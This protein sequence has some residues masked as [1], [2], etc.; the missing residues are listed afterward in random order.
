MTTWRRPRNRNA[1]N[2]PYTAENPN[3]RMEPTTGFTD[4]M[5]HDPNIMTQQY[6]AQHNNND[7]E[8]NNNDN[9]NNNNDDNTIPKTFFTNENDNDNM[10]SA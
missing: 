1:S 5:T 2:A 4:T 3:F 7:N 6:N 9:E 8:N 10:A